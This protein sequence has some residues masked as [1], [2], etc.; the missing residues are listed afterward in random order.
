MDG[1]ARHE[2]TKERDSQLPPDC[3]CILPTNT[4]DKAFYSATIHNNQC[5]LNCCHTTR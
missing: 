3:N 4:K 5:F 2:D 1:D